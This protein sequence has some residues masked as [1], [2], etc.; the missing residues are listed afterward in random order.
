MWNVT[1]AATVPPGSVRTSETLNW[2]NEWVAAP[3]ASTAPA[4][5][6][7]AGDTT[8][9]APTLAALATHTSATSAAATRTDASFTRA[10]RGRPCKPLPPRARGALARDGN[11]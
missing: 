11:G 4:A 7:P 5:A 1:R 8:A 10:R 6:V 2:T 9:P 3:A